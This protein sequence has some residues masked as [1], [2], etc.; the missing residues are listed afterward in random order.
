MKS[1][2]LRQSQR[3]RADV[4]SEIECLIRVIKEIE[5]DQDS[6]LLAALNTE[7]RRLWNSLCGTPVRIDWEPEYFASFPFQGKNSNSE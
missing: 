6:G 7:Q 2:P 3:D 1:P 5:K 4:D